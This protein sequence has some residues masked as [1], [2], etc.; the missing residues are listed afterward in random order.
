[1]LTDRMMFTAGV[2]RQHKRSLLERVE[3]AKLVKIEWRPAPWVPWVTVLH[4]VG[5]RKNHK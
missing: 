2:R 1:M 5:R 3:A 4:R